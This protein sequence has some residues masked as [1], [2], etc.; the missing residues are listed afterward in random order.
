[1]KKYEIMKR[2]YLAIALL[3]TVAGCGKN[4]YNPANGGPAVLDIGGISYSIAPAGGNIDIPVKT[5]TDYSVSIPEENRSWI[6][7]APA[8]TVLSLTIQANPAVTSRTS[9]VSL[10][11]RDDNVLAEI[12]ITQNGNIPRNQ[13]FYT[14]SDNGKVL[15]ATSQNVF[16]PGFTI[17]SNTYFG[18]QSI[19]SGCVCDL[20]IY[21]PGSGCDYENPLTGFAGYVVVPD[22]APSIPE[23]F[24]ADIKT[25]KG[26]KG[27]Y[28]SADNHCLVYEG[29]LIDYV[30][31]DGKSSYQTPEGIRRIGRN[32]FSGAY[33]YLA[34]TNLRLSEGVEEIAEDGFGFHFN[35]FKVIE[36]PSTLKSIG[37][38]AFA[39]CQHIRYICCQALTPPLMEGTAGLQ[40]S[41]MQTLETIFVPEESEELYRNAGGWS[42]FAGKIHGTTWPDTDFSP[43]FSDDMWPY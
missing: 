42:V 16:G 5:N 22:D 24:G 21:P 32:A 20:F 9:S 23:N 41:N 43:V 18:G 4:S 14:S 37:A 19:A 2:L 17:T 40:A 1:M 25:A 11:D 13:I 26:Y 15:P 3:A 34:L 29:T 6:S 36:L 35:D 10:L 33:M 12:F 31:G 27:K 28:A 39:D 38:D 7:A 8:R 30:R